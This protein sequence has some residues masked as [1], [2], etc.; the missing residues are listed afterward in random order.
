MRR[1]VD[2]PQPEGPTST[3]NSPLVIVRLTS[4]TASTS[5][6]NTFVTLSRTIWLT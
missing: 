3:M 4:S 6:A 2:L 1:S 5:P